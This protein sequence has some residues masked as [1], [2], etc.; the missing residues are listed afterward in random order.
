MLMHLAV[1]IIF[2]WLGYALPS[3]MEMVADS[4]MSPERAAQIHLQFL[5]LEMTSLRGFF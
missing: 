3:E 5:I 1:F 2:C 4:K